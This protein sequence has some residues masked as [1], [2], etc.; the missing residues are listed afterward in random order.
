MFDRIAPVYDLMNRVMTV[1]LDLRWRR[2]RRE[3]VVRPGDRVLDARVRNRRPRASRAKRGRRASPARLLGADA[4]ARAPQG[5]ARSSGCSGDLLALPFDDEK[6]RRGDRRLRR[7]Q[8]RRPRARA[9]ASCGACCGPAGGSRSS[10]S[11][12]RAGRCAPFYSLWFDR[13]VPLLGKVLPGGA[14]YTYLPACVQAVPRRRTTLAA[15]LRGQASRDVALPA[16]RR[17]DRRAAHRDARAHE[18]ARRSATTPGLDAVHR[19][20]RGAARARGR[21]ATGRRRGGRRSEALAA[22]GKRLRPLLVLPD[23]P[24]ARAAARGRRR[25]RA[26][27]HGD[28]RARRPDRRR[29]GAP[30]PAVGVVGA[31]APAPRARPATTSSR[32]RSRELAATGDARRSRRSPTRRC[33]SR[34]ARRSSGAR[35]TTRRR[36]STPTSSGARS[37]RGSC[38]RRRAC[39]ARRRRAARRVRRSISGSRS[40]SPTTSSTAPAR[41][42]RRGRSPAPTCARGRRRCRSCSPRSE[43]EVVRRALAGGPLDGALVR[44]AATGALAALP[45]GRAR[46]RGASAGV[47]ERQTHRG[48]ARGARSTA[49]LE[50]AE[51]DG[52]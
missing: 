1:G 44:V 49:V 4:R 45:R 26:R 25:G 7:A 50:R 34:A 43:D 31:T 20:A 3:A 8:R 12:S 32:A 46:L 52:A 18:R 30:R 24:R 28:A 37:R 17:R 48:G 29:R 42:R 11:R 10:R 33:A 2:L 14:A 27:A 9:R 6:L 5:A 19:R 47:P 40:R 23:R 21:G 51:A 38:S 35:R 15:L 39:S 22:G 36:R 41:R 16:L 13:I